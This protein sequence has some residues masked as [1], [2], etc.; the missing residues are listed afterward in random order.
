ME[1]TPE[2]NPAAPFGAPVRSNSRKA[3]PDLYS[4]VLTE[5]WSH[6]SSDGFLKF[7]HSTNITS[8]VRKRRLR[9]LLCLLQIRAYPR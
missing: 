1:N 2:Q 5:I 8:Q 3:L 7:D 4:A 9:P 6:I